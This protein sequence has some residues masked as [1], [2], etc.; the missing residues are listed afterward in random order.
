MIFNLIKIPIDLIEKT[1]QREGY[2]YLACN[3]RNAF[4]TSEEHKWYSLWS[5]Q[6][7]FEALHFFWT[8]IILDL[9]LRYTDK[10]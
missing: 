4:F 6:K 5:C 2:H 1:F 10:L 7:A 8:I 9:A 3:D